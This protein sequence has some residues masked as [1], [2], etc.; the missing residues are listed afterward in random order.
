MARRWGADCME[1][2][3]KWVCNGHSQRHTCT[4][5]MASKTCCASK[6]PCGPEYKKYERAVPRA[7]ASRAKLAPCSRGRG[8]PVR[9]CRG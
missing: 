6:C 8:E 9:A 3:R 1:E 5:H 4:Y 2:G 7:T